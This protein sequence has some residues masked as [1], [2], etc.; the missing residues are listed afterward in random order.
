MFQ[1]E[2]IFVML[3][4]CFFFSVLTMQISFYIAKFDFMGNSFY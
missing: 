2:R 3:F 4:W 1:L